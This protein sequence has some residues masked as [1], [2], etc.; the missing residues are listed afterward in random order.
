LKPALHSPNPRHRRHR[1]CGFQPDRLIR[2]ARRETDVAGLGKDGGGAL[3]V[4]R[5][6]STNRQQLLISPAVQARTTAIAGG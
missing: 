2:L 5:V 4:G 1:G 3:E 6:E